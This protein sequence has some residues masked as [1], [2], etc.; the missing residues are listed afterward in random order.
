MA[1]VLSFQPAG[2]FLHALALVCVGRLIFYTDL[3]FIRRNRR[4]ASVHMVQVCDSCGKMGPA[5]D[6]KVEDEY[7]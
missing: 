1:K 5:D 3:S 6:E 4:P 2:K 7:E